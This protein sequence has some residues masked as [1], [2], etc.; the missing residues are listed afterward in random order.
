MS[1]K[2]VI[3]RY[4]AEISWLNDITIPVELSATGTNLGRCCFFKL[5]FLISNYENLP[6]K[7]I[8]LQDQ[9][10]DHLECACHG[11]VDLFAEIEYITNN[12]VDY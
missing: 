8:F 1:I 3:P 5:Q 11:T 2:L 7:I 10:F 12:A 9:P 6:D 4:K